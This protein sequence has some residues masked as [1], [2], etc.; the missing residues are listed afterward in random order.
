MTK[1][2]V[3]NFTVS[4]SFDAVLNGK[5]SSH[6]VSMGFRLGEPVSI[7][8]A[9]VY[10]VQASRI[11]TEAAIHDAIARGVISVNEASDL[12]EDSKMRHEG[13]A[14]TLSKKLDSS[15]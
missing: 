5:K 15:V 2:Q 14:K 1:L 8:E 10:Q 6:F 11:V 13:I 9:Q 4:Y 12:I 7:E 3:E